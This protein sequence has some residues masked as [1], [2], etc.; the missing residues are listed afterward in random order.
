[1]QE[2]RRFSKLTLAHSAVL[3]VAVWAMLVFST[4]NSWAQGINYPVGSPAGTSGAG[5]AR[6]DPDNLFIRNNVAG[7]TEIA[8]TEEEEQTNELKEQ[9]KGG[10]RT[11]G[12]LQFSVYKYRRERVF[13]N[14]AFRGVDG[15][16][17][18]IN[19]G[20]AGEITYTSKDHRFAFG[21]GGYQ[22]FG[23][24]SKF[25]DPI[26]ELGSRA[27]FFDTRVASNDVALGGAVRLHRTLSVGAAFIFGRAFLDLEAPALQLLA[28]GRIQ[29]A[30]LDVSAIGA[31][32]VNVGIH[33]RPTKFLALAASYKS[34][35]EY[36]LEGDFD[37]FEFRNSQ[38][39]PLR[40]RAEVEFKLPQVGEFGIEIRPHKKVI[41]AADFRFYDYT[42]TFGPPIDVIDRDNG[43]LLQRVAIQGKDVRSV[44][45]G[46]VISATDKT[47]IFLGSAYTSNG[48]P[49][50][51]INPGLVNVGGLDISGGVGKKLRGQWFN[52]S[53]AVILG[54]ERLVGP[55]VNNL[56]P[57]RYKGNGILFS[58]GMRLNNKILP[59]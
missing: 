23:F 53:G 41:V 12:E 10:L 8:I 37:T 27:T 55:P 49:Q 7:M 24:Q 43:S 25:E 14:Q 51:S 9:D 13:P 42:E 6:T 34:E 16:A 58:F 26:D 19:P 31:P 44:R 18:I 36:N 28:F 40:A 33:F 48:F 56:F 35:R 1:M 29:E 17:T 3:F 4:T 50:A 32:G 30:R 47:K 59:F 11:F 38:F 54:R 46:V 5:N 57:G 21:V 39:V 45:G 22:A 20:V 52:I 15:K 2:V